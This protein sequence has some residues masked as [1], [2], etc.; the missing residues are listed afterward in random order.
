MDSNHRTHMRTDL[1]S[2]AFSHSAICPKIIC[3]FSMLSYYTI[4]FS[5]CQYFFYIFSQKLIKQE[6]LTIPPAL[7]KLIYS[8]TLP[9]ISHVQLPSPVFIT[10][11]MV[12]PVVFV[13]LKSVFPKETVASSSR[14]A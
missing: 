10:I 2:A 5:L 14:L 9:Q 8:D 12:L 13:N 1:Q 7:V 11:M 3:T 6:E 4:R